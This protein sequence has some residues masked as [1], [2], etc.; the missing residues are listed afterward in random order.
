MNR[1]TRD[2]VDGALLVE[3]PGSTDEKANAA[4][5][6]IGRRLSRAHFPGLHDA[7]PGARTLLV[8][9]DPEVVDRA[10]LQQILDDEVLETAAAPAREVRIPVR[11]G[12]ARGPDLEN[13]ARG[14]GTSPREF[15][16]L[17]QS[18]VYRVPFIG[19][20]P[21]FPYLTGLPEPLRS[22]RLSSPR[23]RVPSG[24]VGIGG[25]YTGV[26][27]STPPGAWNLIGN[28][29]IRLFDSNPAPPSLLFPGDRARFQDVAE[30]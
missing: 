3:F 5:A 6:A 29:P 30:A 2:V 11:Y 21:G 24:S 9:F 15:A 19:F 13:L 17:H 12:G 8:L 26:Y 25:E 14:L 16:R 27:P 20:A 23:P 1:A 28:A 10:A 7:V 18:A 22:P 4:A